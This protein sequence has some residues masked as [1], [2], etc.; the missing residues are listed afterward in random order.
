MISVHNDHVA[1]FFDDAFKILPVW[2]LPLFPP[3]PLRGV[4]GVTEPLLT[5]TAT[6][7]KKGNSHSVQ[8]GVVTHVDD[9]YSQ[10]PLCKKN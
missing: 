9:L 2:L 4:V 1:V 7:T 5:D 8:E 6:T 3:V 10:M